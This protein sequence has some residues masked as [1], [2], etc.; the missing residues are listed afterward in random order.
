V[1]IL[2]VVL[3][4]VMMPSGA[5][6][7]ELGLHLIE[8]GDIAHADHESPEGDEHGCSGLFHTCAC[9]SNGSLPSVRPPTL[10]II[11]SPE[12]ATPL[13]PRDALGLGNPP[14]PVRPPIV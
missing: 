7:V 11:E 6:L 14:P 12:V 2:A 9:H 1:R 4:V 13:D 3:I 10:A 8:H 5:E